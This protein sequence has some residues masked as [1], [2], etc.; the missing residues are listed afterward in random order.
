MAEVGEGTTNEIQLLLVPAIL[1]HDITTA[2]RNI[3]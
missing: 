3:T 1:I 2:I